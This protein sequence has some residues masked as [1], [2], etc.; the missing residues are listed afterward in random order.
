MKHASLFGLIAALGATTALA[1]VVA[2]TKVMFDEGVVAA[3]LTGVAGDAAEGRKVF[4]NRKQGNCLACHANSDLSEESFHGE[5]APML[6]G[7]ADRWNEAELRGI[8]A[9][10]K[11]TFEDTMMPAF[12]ID[13]GYVRPLE[14][15]DG[16][17]ILTAQQ[18]EDVVAYLMTLKEE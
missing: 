7:V 17:S 1:E 11:M 14:G 2:P 10:A 12:Y 15:F 13:S 5:V 18:V 6:D 3:S 9:N 4:A 16:Q 8:V